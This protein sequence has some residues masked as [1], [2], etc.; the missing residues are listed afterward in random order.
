MLSGQS[1]ERTMVRPR[2]TNKEMAELLESAV[3]ITHEVSVAHAATAATLASHREHCDK[4]KGEIKEELKSING[5]MWAG[6]V[7]L[8]IQ[9]VALVGYFATDSSPIAQAHANEAKAKSQNP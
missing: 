4:D 5:K 7:M 3:K 8:I 2:M 9:L 6:L 1:V